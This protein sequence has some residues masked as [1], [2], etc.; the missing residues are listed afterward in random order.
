MNALMSARVPGQVGPIHA[1]GDVVPGILAIPAPGHT[2]GHTMFEY[3]GVL[4]SGDAV[5]VKSGQLSQFPAFL[6]TDKRQAL[7]AERLIRGRSPRLIC[8]GHGAPD[9]LEPAG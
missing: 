6:I 7:D 4:F 9:R 5:T 2:P 1:E 3:R 8:P